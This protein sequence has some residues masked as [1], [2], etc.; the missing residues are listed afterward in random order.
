M[1]LLLIGWKVIAAL[2]A[3][4]TLRCIHAN[5]AWCLERDAPHAAS[6]YEFRFDD[7]VIP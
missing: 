2:V 6:V 1:T 5:E 3:N 4:L 7:L